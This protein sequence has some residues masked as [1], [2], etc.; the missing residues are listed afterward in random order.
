MTGLVGCIKLAIGNTGAV[1]VIGDDT[2][3][4][5]SSS[6]ANSSEVARLGRIG[7]GLCTV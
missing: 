5:Q 6:S 2:I 7:I 4:P 1:E 3:S